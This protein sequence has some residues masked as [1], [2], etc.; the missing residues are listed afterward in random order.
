MKLSDYAKKLG[1]SYK[2]A[3][4]MWKRGE[5]KATQLAT[6]T[7]IVATQEILPQGVAI[8]TRVSSAEN[9]SNLD[10]QAERL[11]AY[12]IAKG[13]QIKYIVKEVGSGVNDNRK[14]L[15]E[16]LRKDDYSLI[17]CEHKDRLTRVGFNYLKVLLNKQGKDIEVVNLAEERK[18][19]LM[20][21][22][23]A[24]ITSFCAKLYSIKRRTHK[25]ECLIQCLKENQDEISQKA[26]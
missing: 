19:D 25:T 12:C 23:V 7:I 21:D 9:K 15:I 20:Q 22:F 14:K 5:I 13:Y 18:D 6:G 26:S 2:T 1:V 16:L 24:I 3:W 10:S 8:Y 4:R 11:K 17:I